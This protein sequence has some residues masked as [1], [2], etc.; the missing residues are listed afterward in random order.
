MCLHLVIILCKWRIWAL[1]VVT[2]KR[3]KK[4]KK[5]LLL[6]CGNVRRGKIEQGTLQ[7]VPLSS[8]HELNLH[9]DSLC[10]CF[11]VRKFVYTVWN[12]EMIISQKHKYRKQGGCGKWAACCTARQKTAL[13]VIT[14]RRSW[15]GVV[16]D[17]SWV[18]AIGG[19]RGSSHAVFRR[20]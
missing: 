19:G 15:E 3:I 12:A 16:G 2:A 1:T 18:A 13:L 8:M 11:W 17:I 6:L 4:K 5:T 10:K 14:K 20:E 9:K 7:F